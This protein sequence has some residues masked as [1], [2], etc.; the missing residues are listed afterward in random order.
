[1]GGVEGFEEAEGAGGVE[2]GGGDKAQTE[3][4]GLVLVGPG[5]SFL[6]ELDA[7]PADG[8]TGGLGGGGEFGS[9]A[10]E[11]VG[12]HPLHDVA[13]DDV[14]HLVGKD[15]GKA[16]V[17][18]AAEADHRQTDEDEAAGETEG[19][20]G[21]SADAVEGEAAVGIGQPFVEIGADSAEV[22]LC[23]GVGA[24][25]RLPADGDGHFRAD[26]PLGLD[27]L[28]QGGGGGGPD[29]PGLTD[30]G[31]ELFAEIEE[32]TGHLG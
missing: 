10:D 16:A 22:L 14:G 25:G 23:G 3:L 6:K 24:G 7:E 2:A 28:G 9:A 20:G 21:V 18:F 30:P 4:V 5:V 12:G 1:M 26:D 27:P 32:E 29:P 13:F 11:G 19:L 15:E 17:I 31:A 8:L